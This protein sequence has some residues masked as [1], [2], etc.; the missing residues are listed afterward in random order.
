[1][2]F[3]KNEDD[4]CTKALDNWQIAD[5][6][7]GESKMDKT[8]FLNDL[9]KIRDQYKKNK[10][11]QKI[12]EKKGKLESKEFKKCDKENEKLKDKFTKVYLK[13]KKEFPEGVEAK[14]F[15]D[16]QNLKFAYI[17]FRSMD[18][19][20]LVQ[21]A[22]DVDCCKRRCT[23]CCGPYCCKDKYEAMAKKHIF[24]KWPDIQVACAPDNIKWEN[25]GY[26]ARSRRCRMAFVWL[27]AFALVFGS[28]IGIVIMK[29]KTTELKEEFN[30]DMPCEQG[31]DASQTKLAAWEDMQIS[32]KKKR[33]GQITCYCKP[34]L[35]ELKLVIFNR[36]N[37]TDFR[38]YDNSTD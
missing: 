5:I 2:N 7:F 17:T 20:E 3:E 26:S 18:A 35:A 14:N 27:I 23:I 8:E 28:L 13:M 4:K 24:K 34:L 38:Q 1:M 22:Y 15:K 12:L 16:G 6:N 30:L 25:L 33:G 21:N 19:V 31:L 36:V 32:D 10:I 9:T 37:K 11:M 29:D